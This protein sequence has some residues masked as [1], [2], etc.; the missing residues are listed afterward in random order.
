MKIKIICSS[1][2]KWIGSNLNN[3]YCHHKLCMLIVPYVK[4]L[5][6]EVFQISDVF[7]F[8]NICIYIVG[9]LEDGI[10]V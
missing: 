8:W 6:P 7:K 2:S 4:C 1:S 10:Q 3:S 9:Y 5:R